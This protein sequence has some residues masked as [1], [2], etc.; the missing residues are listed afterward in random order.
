MKESNHS[1]GTRTE[2]LQNAWRRFLNNTYTDDDLS[3]IL[4]SLEEDDNL[5]AFYLVSDE[6]WQAAWA[7]GLL[8]TEPDREAFRRQAADML[9]SRIGMR[10][11]RRLGLP[12]PPPARR[13]TGRTVWL[14]AACAAFALLAAS[15]FLL[16]E[17]PFQPQEVT[18]AHMIEVTTERGEIKTIYLPDSSKVSLNAGSSIR[19][20]ATFEVGI[21]Q[22]ELKG[23]AL[24]EVKANPAQP[25]SVNAGKASIQV[26]GTVFDVSTYDEDH[27][28]L[29]SVV[30]GKVAVNISGTQTFLN[31]NEQIRYNKMTGVAETS[32]VETEKYCLWT[33]KTLYF[34]R[35]PV[36]EVVNMLH[37]QYPQW[38]IELAEGNYTS[39]ISGTHDNKRIEAVLTSIAY[40]TGLKWKK[41]NNRFILYP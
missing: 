19:Y 4:D 40:S 7:A 20:P 38:D 16:P 37:R 34:N 21:R 41:E 36:H 31:K 18:A 8:D 32:A 29:V 1:S 10:K 5:R 23:E 15:V 27:L 33:A 25:F 3:F 22:V 35:T 28:L 26:L 13:R 2:A 24:F 14:A 17:N 11:N 9:T 30:S 39:L 6:T 12:L